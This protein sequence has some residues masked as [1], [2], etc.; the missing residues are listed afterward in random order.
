MGRS[1][2]SSIIS[3]EF[4]A[5]MLPF[6]YIYLCMKYHA[7]TIQ[8]VVQFLNSTAHSFT[9]WKSSFYRNRN[10]LSPL[11]IAF[12]ESYVCNFPRSFSVAKVSWIRSVRHLANKV[13]APSSIRRYLRLWAIKSFQTGHR[14]WMLSGGYLTN[15]EIA[16]YRLNH[17]HII[18]NHSVRLIS[19]IV[20][21]DP[22]ILSIVQLLGRGSLTQGRSVWV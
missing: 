12:E 3:F 19:E 6:C 7:K 18:S 21:F 1:L 14:S 9:I 8:R 16:K 22:H 2:I 13:V 15:T 20:Q 11:F 4:Q 10:I 17:H 5:G